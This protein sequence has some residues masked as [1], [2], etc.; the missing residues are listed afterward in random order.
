MANEW[1]QLTECDKCGLSIGCECTLKI[2]DNSL[3]NINYSLKRIADVFEKIW[4]DKNKVCR[5]CEDTL[6]SGSNDFDCK[7]G[8]C[9]ECCVS[10]HNMRCDKT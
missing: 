2:I 8:F 1:N 6:K 9:R 10:H 4:N 5:M 3:Q 7:R